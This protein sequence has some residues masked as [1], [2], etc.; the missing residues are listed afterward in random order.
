MKISIGLPN[1]NHAAFLAQALEGVLSQTYQNWELCIVDDGSPDDSWKIIE[2]Y[3]ARDARIVAERFPC[4]R[5]VQAAIKRS[6]EL[7]AGELVYPAGADDY[8][9][10]CRFFELSVAALER[11]PQAALAY[12]RAELVDGNDGR[13]LGG[14]GSYVPRRHARG[15]VKSTEM[16]IPIQ[17]IPPQEALAQFVS[18]HM[19]IP[20]CALIFRRTLLT[21]SGYYDEALGPQS[22]Y[23]LANAWAALHGAVFIDT[24]VAVGRISEKTYSGSAGE[25]EYFRR[26]ALVEKKLR[27]LSLP[28]KTDERLFAQFRAATINDRLSVPFQRHLFDTVRRFCDSVPPDVF[29]TN[30]RRD[31]ARLELALDERIEKAGAIFDE[32]AGP[33]GPLPP[34]PES[35]PRPW[36]KPVAEFF[37]TLGRVLGNSFSNFGNWLWQV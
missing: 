8:L 11:F 6:L 16:G 14:T 12:A 24:P 29:V 19:V 1:F 9:S 28:Y 27:S 32:V 22:D 35:R 33:I 18:R 4:N 10:D 20:F 2:R 13:P 15:L 25:D 7:C 34:E 37:L 30:A 26:H 17:F 31:C 5:G 21:E 3:R 23:F 36:L